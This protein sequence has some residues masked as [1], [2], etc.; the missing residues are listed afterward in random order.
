MISEGNRSRVLLRK[1]KEW[2]TRIAKA[3]DIARDSAEHELA[4]LLTE[5]N[6]THCGVPKPDEYI[7]DLASRTIK[8]EMKKAAVGTER[9]ISDSILARLLPYFDIHEQV[10]GEHFSGKKMR[11]DAIVTPK[12]QSQWLTKPA[13]LGVEFKNFNAFSKAFDFKDYT[14]WWAQCADYANTKWDGYGYIFVFS[15]NAMENYLKVRQ[16]LDPSAPA[17]AERFW[18]QMGVGDLSVGTAGWPPQQSLQFS[19]QGHKI[20][21]EIAGV[22]CGKSWSMERKFGSR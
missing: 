18:G 10:D 4:R 6:R 7:K 12:D 17:E 13:H 11:I 9:S 3:G 21:C 19:L 8:A 20:W 1:A 22:K 5:F 2:A 16:R 15:F 14:K